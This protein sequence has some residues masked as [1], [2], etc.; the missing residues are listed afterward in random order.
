[1]TELMPAYLINTG[2]FLGLSRKIKIGS[3]NT[4]SGALVFLNIALSMNGFFLY[5]SMCVEAACMHVISCHNH[6]RSGYLP[7]F[8]WCS[9]HTSLQWMHSWTHG[10]LSN[11]QTKP[12]GSKYT[13]SILSP[14]YRQHTLKATISIHL[15]FIH[16][17]SQVRLEALKSGRR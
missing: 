6:A 16:L 8:P 11:L 7:A 2:W 12:A 3:G 4:S 17:F 15:P 13:T 5:Y 1:M 10:P 14:T 9:W